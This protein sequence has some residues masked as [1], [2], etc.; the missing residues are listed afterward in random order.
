MYYRFGKKMKSL[1][2][3]YSNA[4]HVWAFLSLV[5][6]FSF[7]LYGCMN[8]S[9][10]T[11][12]VS[13]NTTSENETL[14]E[15]L[16]SEN[17]VMTY[18]YTLSAPETPTL[19]LVTTSE[20][21]AEETI[22]TGPFPDEVT[23]Y[24]TASSGS[25]YDNVTFCLEGNLLILEIPYS[26]S[27]NALT[28]ANVEFS[29]DGG[30]CYFAGAN[31][32][33][34]PE[35]INENGTIDLTKSPV[36]FVSN[37]VRQRT[38]EIQTRRVVCDLPILYL[39]TDSG[40]DVTD[41]YE[42]V[43]GNLVLDGITYD[44]EIRGRGNASWWKFPQKSYMLRFEDDISFFDML[45][46]DKWVLASTYGDLS[47]I[48][49]CVAMDMASCMEYLEYTP[50]QIPVDVFLN[51]EY[52]GVYTFSEKIELSM[53]KISLF[54]AYSYEELLEME[55][56]DVGF[57]LECG[58]GYIMDSY[59]YG[60]DYFVTS[61]SPGLY[62][63]FPTFTESGSES[64]N[65]IIEYMQATD[66]AITLCSGYE[67]YID[68]DSW[69]DWFIIMELTN[70]TDSAFCRSSFLYKRPGERLMLGPVWDFDMA[71][72]NFYYDNQ[73]Y[74]YWA[75]AEPIYAP[76]QNHYMTYLYESDAFMLAVQARWDEKK[77]ELLQ[78]ALDAIDT[79]AA[80]VSAS[81]VYNNQIRGVSNSEY[82]IDYLRNFVQRRYNW[83]DMSIH[84]SDFNRHPATQSLPLPEELTVSGN[85]ALDTLSEN[86][87][88]L[89]IPL[90]E[91][92]A[93]PE[94]AV[95]PQ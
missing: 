35:Y 39:T 14:S 67:E 16:L 91:E 28:H 78:T 92:G 87:V 48:R 89:D 70:N 10:A 44:M 36:L 23:F 30:S 24:K 64:M 26:I 34:P 12:N 88:I 69:V 1:I 55:E 4:F 51:G 49:N 90:M 19:T 8:A 95:V 71:F 5:F 60:V 61:H 82:Q 53:D 80:A 63:Q 31:S 13:Q 83:I 15:N 58:G 59:T 77:E 57:M 50:D 84:M 6:L 9:E 40:E 47:L 37:G 45:P 66:R 65:Y 79:Y 17:E 86:N 75:T 72:G 54:S 2:K 56:T 94:E 33:T 42:Y 43:S 7:C 85:E 74:E 32:Q 62:F 68:L 46:C 93:L 38:Y 21:T 81:R 25:S 73:T 27:D 41:R 29:L 76:A 11:K 18:T 20:D 52:L 22:I 3:D